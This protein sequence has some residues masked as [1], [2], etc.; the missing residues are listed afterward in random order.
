M[1]DHFQKESDSYTRLFFLKAAPQK[2]TWPLISEFFWESVYTR[3]FCF[4]ESNAYIL[5]CITFQNNN[6][7]IIYEILLHFDK[8][9]GKYNLKNS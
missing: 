1:Y 2:E 7:C 9:L 3:R 5:E 6:I 8:I 4:V